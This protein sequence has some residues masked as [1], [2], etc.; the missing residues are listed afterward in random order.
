MTDEEDLSAKQRQAEEDPRFFG[1]NVQARGPQ[2]F[3]EAQG[4]GPKEV[5]RSHAAEAGAELTGGWLSSRRKES[6]PKAARLT[7]RSEFRDLSRRAR[8]VHTPHFIVLSSAREH[9][10]GRL[11]I[12][13]SSKVG[14]AVARNRI[15]R[16]V[17]E[18]FRRCRHQ[19]PRRDYVIIAKREA[20]GVTAQEAAA[21][22]LAA[23]KAGRE[24]A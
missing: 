21:E 1:E 7:K 23:L 24:R 8:R 5:N 2:S 22:L 15:K 16:I 3:E 12:T 6:F 9:S 20:L 19:L 14:K 4:Q 18:F 10:A 13:V 11:G 17:R